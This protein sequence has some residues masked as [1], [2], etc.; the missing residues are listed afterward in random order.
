MKRRHDPLVQKAE[1]TFTLLNEASSP[2]QYFVNVFPVMKYLPGWVPGAT[3]KKDAYKLRQLLL[4]VLEDPYEMT[5][6][7]MVG[8]EE[9]ILMSVHPN[10]VDRPMI[11][12]S[13]R[14][15]LLPSHWRGFDKVQIPT[16][17]P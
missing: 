4:Q 14:A 6:K 16:S 5:L 11:L 3:F 9:L 15:P 10:S 1:R 2:G 7:M 13:C 17:T 8:I 12:K